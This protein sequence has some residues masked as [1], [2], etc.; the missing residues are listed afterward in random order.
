MKNKGLYKA[1]LLVVLSLVMVL[2]LAACMKKEDYYTKGDVEALIKVLETALS[3]T[4]AA[5]NAKIEAL[6][7]EY[8]TKLEE[9]EV[10]DAATVAAIEALTA[11]YHSKVTELA[12]ADKANG[13]ALKALRQQYLSSLDALQLEDR[14][15]RDEIDLLNAQYTAKI[16]ELEAADKAITEYYTRK[17]AEGQSHSAKSFADRTPGKV[18]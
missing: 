11:T 3:E 5:S 9:L 13:D 8:L 10:E 4:S 7:T 14:D 18:P 1:L 15:T 16:E 12:A 6:E 2:S 17:E